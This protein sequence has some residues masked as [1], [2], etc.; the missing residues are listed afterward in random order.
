MAKVWTA[1]QAELEGLGKGL[2]MEIAFGNG[3]VGLSFILKRLPEKP[4]T[5]AGLRK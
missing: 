5:L 4:F 3:I 1:R 2:G